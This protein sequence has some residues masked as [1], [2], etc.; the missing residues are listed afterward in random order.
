MLCS[1]PGQQVHPYHAVCSFYPIFHSY[2]HDPAKGPRIH[3]FSFTNWF[4]C[5]FNVSFGLFVEV[6]K[7]IFLRERLTGFSKII[8]LF[9]LYF[10]SLDLGTGLFNV[11]II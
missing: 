7:L 2:L 1:N 5:C 8:A 6:A 11:Y 3:S 4:N 10:L 9:S